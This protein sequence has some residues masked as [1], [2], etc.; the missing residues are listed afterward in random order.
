[1]GAILELDRIQR[2][3]ANAARALLESFLEM[4]RL[5]WN[6]PTTAADVAEAI[7]IKLRTL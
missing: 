3:A 6:Q 1:M 7:A 5:P 2:S 4:I